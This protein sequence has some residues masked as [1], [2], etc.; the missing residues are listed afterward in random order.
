MDIHS[1][2]LRLLVK[3]R[4]IG[5]WIF[6]LL[7]ASW[8]R[9]GDWQNVEWLGN[10]LLPKTWHKPIPHSDYITVG[11][12]VGGLA[13]FTAVLLWPKRKTELVSSQT[14]PDIALEWDCRQGWPKWDIVRL[15]NIGTESASNVGLKFSWPELSFPVDFEINVIHANQEV[16]RE[17]QF[18][19][20]LNPGHINVG[21]M[22]NILRD[23]RFHGHAPLEVIV[24][25][26]DRERTAF[27]KP[28]TLEAG[29]GGEWGEEIKITP[30]KRKQ[31]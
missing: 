10:H 6:W 2:R 25:F 27:E 14:G 15:R 13:W 12:V 22:K 11:L 18:V 29:P 5:G 24:K 26:F 23:Q 3:K 20:K 7:A 16:E 30:G 8:K 17:P 19:E 31:L 1:D 28:F 21:H 4:S 9:L